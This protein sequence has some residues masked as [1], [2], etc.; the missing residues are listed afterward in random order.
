MTVRVWRPTQQTRLTV[1]LPTRLRLVQDLAWNMLV[2]EVHQQF[3][4]LKDA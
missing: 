1:T 4:T 2:G 3:V